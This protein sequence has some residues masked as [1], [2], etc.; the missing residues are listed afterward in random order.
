METNNT[1]TNNE[2]ARPVPFIEEVNFLFDHRLDQEKLEKYCFDGRL[3][4]SHIRSVVWRVLLKCLPIKSSEWSEI[5]NRSRNFYGSLKKKL[6]TN[7]REDIFNFDPELNNPLSLQAENPWQKYF[8]DAELR[9]CINKDVERTFPE[10]QFFQSEQMRKMMSDILF[11]YSKQN[12]QLS[13]RQGM[14]EILAPLL[15]VLYFDHE[16]YAHFKEQ[17]G[18]SDLTN[19]QRNLLDTINDPRFLEH[20]AFAMFR[21]LMMMLEKWY[22]NTDDYGSDNSSIAP[23]SKDRIGGVPFCKSKNPGPNSELI[24]KLNMIND[25]MLREIDPALWR[26]LNSLE[27][28]PQIYGI[29]WLRLMFGREFPMHDLLF[30]WDAILAD[31]PQLVLVDYIFIAMLVLIRHLLLCSDYS[32][33]LQY[34]MRYPPTADIH[35]FI[36][37]SLHLKSPK[38]F[39]KP[40]NYRLSHFPQITQAGKPH[41]NHERAQ[42]E[43]HFNNRT[44]PPKVKT[45]D[46]VLNKIGRQ[47]LSAHS[48]PLIRRRYPDSMPASNSIFYTDEPQDD[49]SEIELMKEQVALLQSRL[50]EH[51]LVARVGSRKLLA[52]ADDIDLLGGNA[53]K[54]EKLKQEIREIANQLTRNT[55]SEQWV[56]NVPTEI[57]SN[58]LD[59]VELARE[60]GTSPLQNNHSLNRHPKSL[61]KE[62]ELLEIHFN[63]KRKNF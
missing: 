17:S 44:S 56:Q 50:N 32:T 49:M 3:R 21:Q 61:R 2:N 26:H 14:H 58:G 54:Q 48:T 33:C 22:I 53:E 11:V 57:S 23:L 25:V 28:T 9:D 63:P 30:L 42:E 24:E 20:D 43:R 38:K 55:V 62:N 13:Y 16:S 46:N 59:A 12:D 29:R 7:P 47:A 8:V 19:E 5:L 31:R 60:A 10:M 6:S 1:E 36:Q 4:D 52:I 37:F 39:P 15:F 51:D 40:K 41:P 18:I 45:V 34:L 35:T 27:I